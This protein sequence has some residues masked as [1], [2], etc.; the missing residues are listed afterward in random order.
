MSSRQ[1]MVPTF[2]K[3]ISI[4]RNPLSMDAFSLGAVGSG[5]KRNGFMRS[6]LRFRT[7][8]R[9]FTLCDGGRVMRPWNMQ[10]DPRS[11]LHGSLK[12]RA[13]CKQANQRR[14]RAGEGQDKGAHAGAADWLL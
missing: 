11:N 14:V 10:R 7:I 8:P 5:A 2:T 3:F 1:A 4:A 13:A 6:G 12:A 9:P